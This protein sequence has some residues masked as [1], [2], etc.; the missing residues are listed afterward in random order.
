MNK[1]LVLALPI[2]VS[3]SPAVADAQSVVPDSAFFVGVG[4]SFNSTSFN[5]QSIEA[6]GLSNVYDKATGAF[7]SSGSAGGPPVGLDIGSQT[8]FEPVLQAGYFKHFQ[9]SK[10]LWGAKFSYNGLNISG[11]TENFL[12]PQYGSYGSTPFT[13]NAVVQSF[14]TNISNQFTLLPLVGYSFDRSF[15]YAGVGPTV[16]QINTNVN[17]LIG[18][19]DL[20]GNRTDISGTPQSFSSS[21]W[22]VGGALT[23]GGTYFLDASWFIDVNYNFAM[24]PS[25]TANYSA[26]FNNTNGDT[27]HNY[28]G[29]LIGSS[30]G[31]TTTQTISISINRAF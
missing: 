18:F 2:A 19:A 30:S 15:V 31:K 7:I 23:V 27:S 13:G 9:D 3:L 12:I 25:Q 17:N 28:S 11:S 29:T 22:V 4:G 8:G 20:K 24:T 14:K 6:T 21:Q 5:N 10:W 16:S 26:P 1:L